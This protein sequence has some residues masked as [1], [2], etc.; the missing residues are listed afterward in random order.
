MASPNAIAR[1]LRLFADELDQA[2]LER[3][4]PTFISIIGKIRRYI[5][6]SKPQNLIYA[7]DI[8]SDQVRNVMLRVAFDMGLFHHLAKAEAEGSTIEE[9][10]SGKEVDLKLLHRILRALV[11]TQDIIQVDGPRFKNSAYTHAIATTWLGA[12]FHIANEVIWPAF[13]RFPQFL[14]DGGHQEPKDSNQTT[15][16]A[17]HNSKAFFEYIN[18]DPKLLESWNRAMGAI[19]NPSIGRWFELWPVQEC[20]LN[21][22]ESTRG[23]LLVDVGGGNEKRAKLFLDSLPKSYPIVVQDL[24]GVIAEAQKSSQA[25]ANI[26]LMSHDFFQDQPVKG[27]RSYW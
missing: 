15:S 6:L 16:H 7:D 10:A 8:W 13:H 4:D 24:P 18:A 23:P 14:K 9:L 25:P 17:V 5:R 22:Y 20:L 2:P 19:D 27:A 26:E 11:A 3:N 1:Q 21:G 12:A